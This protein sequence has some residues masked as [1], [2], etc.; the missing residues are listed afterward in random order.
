MVKNEK[1]LPLKAFQIN[2]DDLP[3]TENS[4]NRI[5]N[6]SEQQL[7]QSWRVDNTTRSPPT[8]KQHSYIGDRPPVRRRF[9]RRRNGKQTEEGEKGVKL[10][11][12]EN[13]VDLAGKELA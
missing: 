9:Y 8:R 10:A 7:I 11:C 12:R 6:C 3:L 5:S 4:Y 2:C 13:L 1:S